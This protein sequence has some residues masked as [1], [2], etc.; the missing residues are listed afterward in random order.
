MFVLLRN[1]C[2]KS[3]QFSTVIRKMPNQRLYLVQHGKAES[4]EVNPERPLTVVGVEQSQK[5]ATSVNF[6]RTLTSLKEIWCST[7]TRAEATAGIFGNAMPSRP[8]V[9]P[10][11]DILNPKA[12]VVDFVNQELG[13]G[14]GENAT[15]SSAS[16]LML[17]GHLPFLDKLAGYLL[18]GDENKS[19]V[20]FANSGVLCLE[21]GEEESSFGWN[22][23]SGWKVVSFVTPEVLSVK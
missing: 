14:I 2:R 9:V 10:K 17:V 19:V 1:H 16:S 20:Q 23:V 21:K 15:G 3:R 4:E 7:K 12:S 11:K 8:N 13:K 6:A 18:T 5:M 22:I